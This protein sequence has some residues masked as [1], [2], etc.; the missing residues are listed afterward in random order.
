MAFKIGAEAVIEKIDF[1]GEESISKMR[2]VKNYRIHELDET[3]R[4]SRTRKEARLLSETKRLGIL[5]PFIYFIDM[6]KGIIVMEYIKGERLKD[7]IDRIAGSDDGSG[8]G[9]N[10]LRSI[11]MRIGMDVG[12][13]HSNGI[14]HGDLTTSNMLLYESDVK[15]LVYGIS[16]KEDMEPDMVPIYFIDFSLG[17]KNAILENMGEDLDVFFKAFESTHPSLLSELKYFWEGYSSVNRQHSEVKERLREIKK[18]A[19]YR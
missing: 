10:V 13:M 7:L 11:M 17:E 1:L 8:S 4:R 18:R 3:L 5:A 9:N 14:T 12:K 19:R 6:E 15:K 16:N 2:V